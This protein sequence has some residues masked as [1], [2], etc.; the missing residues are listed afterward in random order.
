MQ[1]GVT[2]GAACLPHQESLRVSLVEVARKQDKQHG[3]QAGQQ[4]EK[5]GAR[6]PTPARN[7]SC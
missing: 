2:L 6:E 7:P 3:E 1:K 5:P 4:Q